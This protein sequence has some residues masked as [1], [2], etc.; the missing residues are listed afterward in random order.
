M[1]SEICL[2]LLKQEM[3]LADSRA[4]ANTGNRIAARIAIIAMTTSNSIRVK[5]FLAD[6]DI[7][8]RLL[9]ARLSAWLLRRNYGLLWRRRCLRRVNTYLLFSR[10]V[11]PAS[12][13]RHAHA[14]TRHAHTASGR[15]YSTAHGMPC[16]AASTGMRLH[17]GN[18]VCRHGRC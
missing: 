9:S 4:W 6:N 3:V 12:A 2:M 17:L 5:P 7:D 15:A 8:G 18:L 10:T 1:P 14:A 13:A 11:L 16:R